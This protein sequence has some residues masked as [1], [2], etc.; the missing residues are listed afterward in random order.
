MENFELPAHLKSLF[1]Y[2]IAN[3][4]LEDIKTAD[5][6]LLHIVSDNV[7]NM[8]QNGEPG[9]EDMV[10]KKVSQ[11]IKDE[12]LFNYKEPKVNLKIAEKSN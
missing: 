7:L 9:W 2:L 3:N 4:K 10:P 8:I 11:A 6:R 12:R 1:D 5:R